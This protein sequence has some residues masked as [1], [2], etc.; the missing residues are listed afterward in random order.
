[1]WTRVSTAASACR[2]RG[3]PAREYEL[4]IESAMHI[5]LLAFETV[6]AGIGCRVDGAGCM[7]SLV[8]GMCSDVPVLH[9]WCRGPPDSV[10]E[11]V[12]CC[13]DDDGA[14]HGYVDQQSDTDGEA[15]L[16]Q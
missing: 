11:Q 15:G 9:C 7:A 14:H 4:L 13:G 12:Q 5:F 3:A 8:T 2:I 10:A 6:R 1:M 16:Q